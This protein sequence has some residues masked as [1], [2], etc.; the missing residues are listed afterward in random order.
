MFNKILVVN[1]GEIVI[2]VMCVVNELGKKMVV[3]YVE[4]DKLGLYCFKVDEVYCIGVGLGLVVVYLSIF[5]IICVVWELGVDVIYLGYGFLLEN[6]D[7]VDVCVVVG[8]VFIGFIVDM[9]CVFGDKVSVWCVVIKV[10]VLVIFVIEVL[11]DDMDVIKCEVVEIGYFL[12]LKVSW[13]GGGCGM[14]LI[15]NF[16]ELFEKVCEGCCEVEVVFGNGEG[17]LEKMILCVCYVEVQLLGDSYGGFYYFYECDC[18]VQCC[19]QKVVECVFVFYLM[20]VQCDEVCGFVLKIGQ[21]VG[22]CNVG[23]VEFLMDM[24]SQVFYFI[25]VNLCVQVEYIVIEEVIGIDIVQF[26]IQIVEG[27]ML[28][29][30]IGVVFQVEVWLNGYVL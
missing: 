4:E 9:M 24:D 5:E 2:C 3:V 8:I 11:G 10:G 20:Q 12:M 23:M 1:C 22:Y 14:C 25:E 18:I 17:Y 30:V 27:V 28:V 21:V 13:G 16:E 6:F 15:Q 7:F 29:E 26:Q 19:N